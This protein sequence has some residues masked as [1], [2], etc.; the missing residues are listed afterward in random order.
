M[1]TS[2]AHCELQGLRRR[3]SPAGW[4]RAAILRVAVDDVEAVL[5][6]VEVESD[7]VADDGA[8]ELDPGTKRE[9][10]QCNFC[11]DWHC[12]FRIDGKQIIMERVSV[13]WLCTSHLSRHTASVTQAS[14]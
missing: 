12:V 13:T 6:L 2:P 8:V 5:C 4:R 3:Y 1:R 14:T 11:V 10:S 9:N 7:T